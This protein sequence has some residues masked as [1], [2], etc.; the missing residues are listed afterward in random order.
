M[1]RKPRQFEIGNI[2]HIINRGVDGR[3]IFLKNQDYSRFILGLEFFN[4]NEDVKILNIIAPAGLNPAI[5][6]GLNPAGQPTLRQEREKPKS[7]IVELMAFTLMP[8]HY[9]LIVREIIPKGISLYMQKIG[10]Y[11]S[12]FNKQYNRSGTLFESSYKYVEIKTDAQLFVVFNYVHTNPIELIEPM[13]KDQQV[14][15]FDKAKEFLENYKWSSYRDYID[16]LTFP[17]TINKKFFLK[18]FG[19][20]DNCRQTVEEWIKFKADNYKQR[21]QF[22]PK[23]FE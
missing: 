22:N 10:G 11:T 13:W 19:N 4:S 5:L 9:H 1:P 15:N 2:Y 20:S 14:E 3:E 16:I 7:P 12:Y 6:A 23:D 17:D 18:F 21:N 8:N